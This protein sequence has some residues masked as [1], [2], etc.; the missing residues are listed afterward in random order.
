MNT[1]SNIL[2]VLLVLFFMGSAACG[3]SHSIF[4]AIC[5]FWHG[6]SFRTFRTTRRAPRTGSFRFVSRPNMR[7]G[8]PE[9][10]FNFQYSCIAWIASIHCSLPF[11]PNIGHFW[12]IF[13]SILCFYPILSHLRFF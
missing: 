13:Q 7:K 5:L 6:R 11:V 2:F 8:V 10:F 9:H 4:G 12:K 3:G 1:H